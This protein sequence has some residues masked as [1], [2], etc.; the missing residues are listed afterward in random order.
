M[1]DYSSSASTS[2]EV[3]NLKAANDA[4]IPHFQAHNYCIEDVFASR[5]LMRVPPYQRSYSW[6]V[7]EATTLLNDVLQSYEAGRPHFLGAMVLVQ[8]SQSEFDLI[9]GQQRLTTL[10]ILAAIIR[11]LDPDSQIGERLAEFLYNEQ[12]GYYRLQLN[13]FDL[14][15]F[16]DVILRDGATL[17]LEDESA[18][19][20]VS[21]SRLHIIENALAL[22]KSLKRF[23]ESERAQIA[24]HLLTECLF[25]IVVVPDSD[26]GAR[27]FR[28]LNT[29]GKQPNDHDILKSELFELAKL[30]DED[31]AIFGRLWSEYEI[32]LGGS[33]FD[34]LLRQIRT[35]YDPSGRDE[36]ITGFKSSVI[37]HHDPLD[38]LQKIL[39]R[40]VDACRQIDSANVLFRK[41]ASQINSYLRHLATL[42]HN[43]WRAPALKYLVDG[44][45]DGKQA[46][47]FFAGL[48]RL[49]FYLQFAVTDRGARMRRYRRVIDV[50]PA[51]DLLFED[52]G[53][54]ALSDEEI[55]RLRER[56]SGRFPNYMQ[57]KSLAFKLNSLLPGGEQLPFQEE[58]TLEH[59]LPRNPPAESDWMEAWPSPQERYDIAD[60]IGNFA[61]LSRD[62]NQSAD[63]L[64]YAQKRKIYFK[65]RRA[66][67]ALTRHVKSYKE[68]TREAV[69]LRTEKL[70]DLLISAWDF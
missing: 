38:F 54:F 50:L 67:Y 17:K 68:W 8:R 52:D 25:V 47:L 13:H 20:I 48:E 59:I 69:T 24:N 53:P 42:D 16:E 66:Q 43:G 30:S 33:A 45:E 49:G 36:F 63:R 19:D 14:K 28:V 61:L 6:G 11:D 60:T 35:I 51:E 10:S 62:Q 56:L 12:G 2:K 3:Q 31:A 70:V 23:T 44:K 55:A 15:F 64:D 1:R 65:G 40:Y 39:P 37:V 57:R 21:E 4:T 29:R 27:V 46:E 7:R 9:D 26:S 5:P 22:Q 18:K 32:R 58:P 34:D 41:S